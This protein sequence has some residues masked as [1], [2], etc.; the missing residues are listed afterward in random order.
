MRVSRAFSGWRAG[1]NSA[2]DTRSIAEG[3]DV[4]NV[5]VQHQQGGK[6]VDVGYD[7]TFAFVYN[8]FYPGRAIHTD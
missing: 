4:G 3:R 7:V 8:A 1:Q 5:V 2:L 6:A